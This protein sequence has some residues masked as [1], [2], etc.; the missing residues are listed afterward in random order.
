MLELAIDNAREADVL[1]TI[2]FSVKDFKD[3]MND[4]LT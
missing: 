4:N 2:D 1:D 3:C